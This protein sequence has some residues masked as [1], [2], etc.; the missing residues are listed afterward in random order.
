V[1]AA[2]DAVTTS[3]TL[4]DEHH[5]VAFFYFNRRSLRISR[6]V[7]YWDDNALPQ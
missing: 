2:G 5:G 6:A 1:L 3:F 7:F 4:N